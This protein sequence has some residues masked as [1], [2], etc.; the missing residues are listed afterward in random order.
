MKKVLLSTLIAGAFAAPVVFAQAVNSTEET[1]VAAQSATEVPSAQR[2]AQRQ[3]AFRMPSQRI[4]ARLAYLRTALKIT[5]AQQP[6]WENFANVLRAQARTTDQRIA[7]RHAQGR[8]ARPQS[9]AIER[10]ERM[11]ARMNERSTRLGE[12]VHAAK[13]LYASFTPEQR[14]VADEL[15][16]RQGRGGH[17]GRH[18]SRGHRSGA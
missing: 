13:P 7:E 15:M 12:V 2:P 17:R 3:H 11:Q 16:S 18:H 9:N 5:D 6:Q 1:I 14:Q 4:E 8:Q 10:L